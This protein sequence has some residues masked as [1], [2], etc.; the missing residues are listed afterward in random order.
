MTDDLIT[1]MSNE[2]AVVRRELTRT[3]SS[4]LNPSAKAHRVEI[5]ILAAN[6]RTGSD[7]ATVNLAAQRGHRTPKFCTPGIRPSGMAYPQTGQ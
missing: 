5:T 2:I 7:F 3:S 1:R 4:P 6:T